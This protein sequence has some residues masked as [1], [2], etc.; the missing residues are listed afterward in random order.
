[1]LD[2]RARLEC[3]VDYG[4]GC[5]GLATATPFVGGEDDAA[6]AVKDT[7]TKGLCREA[8]EHGRVDGTD[9]RTCEEGSDGL[10]CHGKVNGDR[11]AFLDTIRFQHI[12]DAGDFMQQFSICD[13][14]AFVRFISLVDDRS[15][16]GDMDRSVTEIPEIGVTD[17]DLVRMFESPTINTIVRYIQGTLWKPGDVTL[18]KATRADSLEGSVPVQRLAGDL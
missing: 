16:R 5:N 3:R 2:E 1:M 15:L 12:G 18:F 9:A 17:R 4:L 8:S 13:L 14:S 6:A 7:V 10:P 11:I